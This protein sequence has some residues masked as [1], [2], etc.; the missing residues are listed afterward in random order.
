MEN[1]L[2]GHD[3]GGGEAGPVF[4]VNMQGG[5]WEPGVNWCERPV[6]AEGAGMVLRGQGVASAPLPQ[7]TYC[8]THTVSA[9]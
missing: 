2:K 9:Q 8:G 4:A 6:V 7:A 5:V 3:C 1:C